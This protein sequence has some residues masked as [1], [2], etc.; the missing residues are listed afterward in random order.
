MSWMSDIFESSLEEPLKKKRN[1]HTSSTQNTVSLPRRPQRNPY[2][3][4]KCSPYSSLCCSTKRRGWE[5]P[6]RPGMDSIL[7]RHVGATSA[8]E[9]QLPSM[10]S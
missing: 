10:K 1:S 3:N 5:L 6:D 2:A 9:Q 7:G 8:H 4:N